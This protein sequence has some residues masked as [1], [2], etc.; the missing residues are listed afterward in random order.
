MQEFLHWRPQNPESLAHI[1]NNPARAMQKIIKK[2][3]KLLTATL[4]G[5][6][7]LDMQ[8]F[9]SGD[10]SDAFLVELENR[11]PYVFLFFKTSKTWERLSTL[12]NLPIYE[13]LR[14]ELPMAIPEY[15]YRH[16]ESPEYIAYPL[17]EGEPLDRHLPKLKNSQERF[18]VMQD[19]GQALRVMH[20]FP[21]EDDCG[22]ERSKLYND[23]A[24]YLDPSTLRS[25][26]DPVDQ[27]LY[28]RLLRHKDD[29]LDEFGLYTRRLSIIHGDLGPEHILRNPD[30]GKLGMI[31]MEH[32]K[33][34]DPDLD[35]FKLC[36]RLSPPLQEELVLSYG[37]PWP[38][39]FVRKCQFLELR[40]ALILL[41]WGNT[42]LGLPAAKQAY[43]TIRQHT[44]RD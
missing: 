7:V 36:R 43:R 32:M 41:Q 42:E 39:K 22:L 5:T 14:Q 35:L 34:G 31:D 10:N 20:D 23:F 9:G 1:E 17:I 29:F 18:G 27:Q 38:G 3:V 11:G 28:Q 6:R 15:D 37:H 44:M 25:I 12:S 21:C 40:R 8:S 26:V 33:V 19:V 4:V 30:D 24:Y 13:T 16:D 2:R